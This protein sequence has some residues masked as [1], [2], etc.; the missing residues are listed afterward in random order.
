[1]NA[2]TLKTMQGW[3]NPPP[4]LIQSGQPLEHLWGVVPLGSGQTPGV[5]ELGLLS[6]L[7]VGAR[8]RSYLLIGDAERSLSG[9]DVL[10]FPDGTDPEGVRRRVE[11]G[12][13]GV[14][15]QTELERRLLQ[16]GVD[17]SLQE[18]IRTGAETLGRPVL[19]GD[20]ILTVLAHSGQPE[21]DGDRWEDFIRSGYA[22]DFQTDMTLFDPNKVALDDGF[23]ACRVQNRRRGWTDLLI[24]LEQ[25]G[26]VLGHLVVSGEGG[27]F[28]QEEYRLIAVLCRCILS[29]LRQWQAGQSNRQLSGEQ[30]VGQ[31]FRGELRGEL[32]KFR[33]NLLQL[34][35][36]G[37]FSV[38]AI[39]LDGYHPRT[40][41][42]STIRER[43]EAVC[44]GPSV[45]E[46]QALFLLVRSGNWDGLE[47]E[48]GE[49]GMAGGLSR[50][51][52]HLEDAPR[53]RRQA[54]LVL[55]ILDHEKVGLVSYSQAEPNILIDGL[56]A[57][58]QDALLTHPVV[59]RLRELDQESKFSFTETLLAYLSCAQRPGLTCT[60]LH[61][62]R[63]TLDYRLHRL[64]EL[65]EIDWNNGKE[66]AVLL[67]ALISQERYRHGA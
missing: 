36:E 21:G 6:R 18:L 41:S 65:V 35:L 24:D 38:A 49:N 67:L 37:T 45:L 48:L 12:L 11:Q 9:S 63:N 32:L 51:F 62:H 17:G 55:S 3:F 20:A 33:A 31:L 60:R 28:R 61:I 30:F 23:F 40:R 50:T 27:G 8:G 58:L 43:L 34:P 46:S 14:F 57:E 26:T 15:R 5:A 56:P 53:F 64:E 47:R 2:V 29:Q 13:S 39:R 10:L 25:G 16:S 59:Q 66:M 19:L 1:M 22:P 52:S 54:E 4:E 42:I 7:P 44:G